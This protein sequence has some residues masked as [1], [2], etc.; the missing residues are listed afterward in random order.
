MRRVIFN[1][2]GGVGKSSITVNLAAINAQRGNKTLVIDLD[3]Q[4][5]SSQYLLGADKAEHSVADFF[6][7]TLAFRLLAKA[8]P[9][10]TFI[11]STNYENLFLI[12]SSPE[13]EDLRN[14]LEGKHKIYKLRDALVRLH[15]EYHSIYIDTPPAVGFYTLSAL[16]A[17]QSC[18]IPF[19]CDDFSRRAVYTLQENVAEIRE[20][21]NP[22]L[23]VEGIIVNQ[24]LPRAKL[25]RRLVEQLQKEGQP[26]LNAKL[27]AS[28]K[29]R[30]SHEQ[31]CPLI[32][33]APKH[34]LTQEFLTLYEEL[35]QP[36]SD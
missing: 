8:S 27:S 9:P 16:I 2:K 1:Q 4:G 7:E 14:K 6:R 34:K 22:D 21:H 11:S 33:F 25:P 12:A 18:L 20:D 13:L 17:A 10:E 32:H 24:F 3:P 29:M 15:E 26:I 28:V 5:N 30:E 36:P 35:H 31:S 19:D 23:Q